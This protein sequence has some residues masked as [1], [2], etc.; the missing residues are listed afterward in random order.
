MADFTHTP[1][2]KVDV[3]FSAARQRLQKAIADLGGKGVIQEGG[4]FGEATEMQRTLRQ[5][6][7][8][9]LRNFN[10]TASAIAEETRNPGLMDRFRMPQGSGD[11][12][13]RIKAL[14]M[15]KAIRD[16][17]LADEFTAHGHD[18][19]AAADL[20]EQAAGFKG[21]EGEQGVA[22]AEQAGATAALPEVLRQGKSAKKTLDAIFNNR[23]KGN[24]EVLGAWKTA[25]HTERARVKR[26]DQGQPPAPAPG[27][28]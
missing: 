26:K 28:V 12:E 24:A 5:D 6:L 7:E 14:A 27:S 15:A 2:T 9:E 13:L 8:E 10:R 22:L 18:E 21:S 4:A 23:Y 16:L 25:S 11:S 19:D 17:N 3:K 20:E 1:P